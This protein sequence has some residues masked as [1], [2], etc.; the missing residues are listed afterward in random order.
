MGISSRMKLNVSNIPQNQIKTHEYVG[1]SWQ[2]T[3]TLHKETSPALMWALRP[4]DE[5]EAITSKSL[6]AHRD[7]E[8]RQLGLQNKRCSKACRQISYRV[9]W[10]EQR[11]YLGVAITEHWSQCC[12][13][14][15]G[16]AIRCMCARWPT[17]LTQLLQLLGG[18]SQNPNKPLW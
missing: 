13:T 9:A 10:R 16:R 3:V 18:V 2:G 7:K 15:Q 12:K 1:W 14:F 17:N 6:L 5:E 4:L 11:D 8:L